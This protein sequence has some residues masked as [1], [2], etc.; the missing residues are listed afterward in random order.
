MIRSLIKLFANGGFDG[1]LHEFEAKVVMFVLGALSFG[2][3][4]LFPCSALARSVGIGLMAGGLGGYLATPD[5]DHDWRTMEE[6]RALRWSQTLG[7]IWIA[8][9]RPYAKVFGHRSR[10]T[11]SWRGTL[12]RASPFL[13]AIILAYWL[14]L[15]GLGFTITWTLIPFGLAFLLAWLAQDMVHYKQDGL[16]WL[17][18]EHDG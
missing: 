6:Y 5:L 1:P 12:L 4:I 7:M 10:W 3:V 2:L 13:A 9:W 17:G 11:H 15:S 8:L 16:N 18:V 14:V